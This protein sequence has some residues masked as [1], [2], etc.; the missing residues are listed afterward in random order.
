M[1]NTHTVPLRDLFQEKFAQII[2]YP[3]L[4][5]KELKRRIHEMETLG[6]KAVSFVGE[7]KIGEISVM[8]KG[9]VGIVLLAYTEDRKVAIKI[10]RVDAD[11]RDMRHEAEMLR[12]ANSV[13]VGPQLIDF[14][15]NFLLMEFIDGRRL[16]LWLDYIKGEENATIR[17]K[18]VL[19]E[20][21]EQ[22][23]RLD[24]IGLDH[25][26]LSRASKHIII[27]DDDKPWIL[28]FESASTT[29]RKTNVTS[30]CQF[31]FLKGKIADQISE[32]THYRVG[33]LIIPFLKAYKHAQSEENFSKIIKVCRLTD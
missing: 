29:R 14:T 27:D 13:D 32:I 33:E 25:G 19:R 28:D 24:E 15:Q 18:R 4:D 6:I 7:K 26:E 17:T 9:C 1:R 11:R 2:C 10:R 23:R 22:C 12:I 16:P 20:I 21:L 3:R 5:W 8:G 31:L 30:I